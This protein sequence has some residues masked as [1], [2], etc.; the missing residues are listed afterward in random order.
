M[1]TRA[2]IFNQFVPLEVRDIIKL[3]TVSLRCCLYAHAHAHAYSSKYLLPL[4]S[5]VFEDGPWRD[6]YVRLGY[7]PR[8]D[9]D[10]RL[11][12]PSFF[13]QPAQN[14]PASQLPTPVLPQHQPPHRAPVGRHPAARAAQRVRAGPLLRHGRAAF[15]HLRR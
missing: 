10:A 14:L 7:D 12:V 15:A 5:Y 13:S 2:A 9:P 6:T 1:W 4:V 8:V 11:Y 3:A